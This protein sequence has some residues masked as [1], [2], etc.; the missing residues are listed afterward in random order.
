MVTVKTNKSPIFVM[1]IDAG[2]YKT[3][4]VIVEVTDSDPIFVSR[5]E[6]FSEGWIKGD[7]ADQDAV[8][9]A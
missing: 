5:A 8:R 9:P 1:G 4:C 2:S 7:I 6:I 3:R